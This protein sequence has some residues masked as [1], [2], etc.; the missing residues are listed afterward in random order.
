MKKDKQPSK[1]QIDAMYRQYERNAAFTFKQFYDNIEKTMRN[2]LISICGLIQLIFVI[3]NREG[4]LF[5][6]VS[7]VIVFL[8]SFVLAKI[9][10]ISMQHRAENTEV[11]RIERTEGYTQSFF[12]AA[13]A[14]PETPQFAVASMLAGVYTFIGNTEMALM[15][16]K[17]VDPEVYK[18]N[19][20]NAQTYYA[21]LLTAQLLDG[22][23]DHAAETYKNGFYYMNTYKSSPMFGGFVSA[24]LGMYEYYCGRYDISLQLLDIGMRSVYADMRPENRLGDENSLTILCYW[25][26]MNFAAMGDKAAAWDSINYCKNFYKTP[27]YKQLCEKLLDDMAREKETT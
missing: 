23:L 1:K 9:R 20:A 25:K 15:E 16:L 3:V 26:A 8:I 22:D 24:A 13:Y 14:T 17:K 12:D 7:L 2:F 27:Y 5:F 21:A 10:R 18:K 4:L 19:P 11:V 6:A